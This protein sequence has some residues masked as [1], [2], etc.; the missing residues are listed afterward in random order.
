ME[1]ILEYGLDYLLIDTDGIKYT[2]SETHARKLDEKEGIK[3][4]DSK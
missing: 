3:N 2:D 1:K 4:D